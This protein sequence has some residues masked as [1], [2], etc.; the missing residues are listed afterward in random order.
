MPLRRHEITVFGSRTPHQ[1]GA[2]CD[3]CH[4][5]VTNPPPVH[6]V[7][8]TEQE[9]FY[10]LRS[11]MADFLLK[12]VYNLMIW[13]HLQKYRD[14]GLLLL[15]V[16]FGLYLALGHG[17]G[18]VVG[19]PETWAWLGEHM[20]MFGLGFAP[21]FWGFL[22]M[23]AEFVCALLVTLGL[24]TRPAALFVALNMFVVSMAHIT[25][26][27][28]GGPETAVL[29]GILCLS[30]VFIGPGKYSLDEQFGG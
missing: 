12:D 9:N 13:S 16:V 24:A 21:A 14:L 5:S 3:E 28:D 2:R 11:G 20:E 23:L 22:A 27:V 19:G 8:S 7:S 6:L 1:V 30:L 4:V 10:I 26:R 18:K 29:Y 25:G 15:R 17:W